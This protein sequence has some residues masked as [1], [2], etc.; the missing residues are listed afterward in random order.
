MTSTAMANRKADRQARENAMALYLD[1]E[2]KQI[3]ESPVY[4]ENTCE[5]MENILG[6]VAIIYYW[7]DSFDCDA[8]RGWQ[9]FEGG[10]IAQGFHSCGS[11]DTA[12]QILSRKGFRY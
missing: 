7:D 6:D 5:I 12:Y 8:C 10:D 1:W 4:D 11:A 3:A 9:I 2:K